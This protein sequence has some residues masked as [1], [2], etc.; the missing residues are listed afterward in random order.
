[1]KLKI[2]TALVA[3]TCLFSVFT[4][5][6][7]ADGT[8]SFEEENANKLNYVVYTV[9]KGDT[10]FR[11]GLKYN[12]LLSAMISVNPQLKNPNLIFPGDKINIPNSA[13]VPK[14]PDVTQTPKAPGGSDSATPISGYEQQVIDLVNEIRVKNGLKALIANA[15][16]SEVAREK[17]K[18]MHDKNYFSHNSPTYGTPFEMMKKFG[19]SY[20]TAGEN[21]AK[22]QTT[23]QQ[24]VDAWMNSQGHRE[25]ILN[26]AFTQI[27]VGYYAD[28][29][30]WTQMF[31][32]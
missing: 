19:I 29:H 22:G 1:M 17:S 28:G 30:Y 8:T 24:V 20:K 10:L 9:Q 7:F 15:K 16:L 5:P 3:I 25:N 18:D 32:G 4:L 11:I 27:G 23:P 21:I 6:A 14:A 31:I 2:C 13:A 26:S 12:Y